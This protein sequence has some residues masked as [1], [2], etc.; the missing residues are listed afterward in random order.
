MF[1]EKSNY[2]WYVIYARANSE[3]KL[4]EN[5]QERNIDCYFPTK[6]VLKTWSDRKK[7]VD[8]PLFRCYIFVR[9][10][11]KEFFTALNTDSVVCYISFGGKAKLFL[12]FRLTTSDLFWRS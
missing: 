5:L 12:M 4:L 8:E 11:Y 2:L 3:K 10:S 6:K 9:V 1:Y 7:W